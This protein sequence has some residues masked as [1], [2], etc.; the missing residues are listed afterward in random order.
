MT[1]HAGG[2][3]STVEGIFFLS[4]F[5]LFG[6]FVYAFLTI[7]YLLPIDMF[8]FVHAYCWRFTAS[9]GVVINVFL[10]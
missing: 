3:Y 10:V 7:K 8:S 2:R 5:P 4:F 1:L 9:R 6:R